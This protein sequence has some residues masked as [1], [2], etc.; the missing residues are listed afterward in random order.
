MAC[1]RVTRRIPTHLLEILTGKL[2]RTNRWYDMSRD[3]AVIFI[4][5]RCMTQLAVHAQLLSLP[6]CDFVE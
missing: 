4:L 2:F 3:H 1:G 5:S 6:E